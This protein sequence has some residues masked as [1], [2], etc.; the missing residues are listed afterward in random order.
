MA[1]LNWFLTLKN[2]ASTDETA[3]ELLN[4]IN[5]AE[6]DD[7]KATA[8]AEAKEY[9]ESFAENNDIIS[10]PVAEIT[11]TPIEQPESETPT[12]TPVKEL[13]IDVET[14]SDEPTG[15]RPE[16]IPEADNSL[17]ERI[18]RR[19]KIAEENI[20]K[21]RNQPITL[22]EQK[23]AAIEKGKEVIR[24]NNEIAER[25]KALHEMIEKQ[26]AERRASDTKNMVGLLTILLRELK[27]NIRLEIICKKHNITRKDLEALKATNPYGWAQCLMERPKLEV[28]LERYIKE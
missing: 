19:Q 24:R 12:E 23:A 9:V 2:M 18:R 6:T 28:E 10:A 3:K 7:A 21:R 5:N 27:L 11:E 20:K 1:K 22:S 14:E 15:E 8:K 17:I 4:A 25:R 13:E 26:Q 16:P